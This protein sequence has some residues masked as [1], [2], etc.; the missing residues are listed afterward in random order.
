MEK[1]EKAIYKV[2]EKYYTLRYNKLKNI[3]VNE[4]KEMSDRPF[5][6]TLARM[7]EKDI[8]L[9]TETDKQNVSYSVDFESH[10]FEQD[11]IEYFDTAFSEYEKLFDKFSDERE[12]LSKIDQSGLLLT[13][14][15]SLYLIKFRFDETLSYSR[16]PKYQELKIKLQNLIDICEANIYYAAD[17]DSPD[18]DIYYTS[19]TLLVTEYTNLLDEFKQ[20][21]MKSSQVQAG[22]S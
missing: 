5:R 13:Y 18:L 14:L 15:K 9:R 7:V 20:N 17:D 8:V 19:D 22:I 2:L 21:L 3:V 12:Q 10:K 1:K 6:E 4:K 16:H 11:G